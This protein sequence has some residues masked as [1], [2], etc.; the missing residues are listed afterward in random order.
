MI[1]ACFVLAVPGRAGDLA[2][3]KLLEILE[4]KGF[5]TKQE[6][7]TVKE[8]LE[9]ETAENAAP[10]DKEVAVIYDEG[11]QFR[12]RDNKTFSARIGGLVQADAVLFGSNYP[13][14]NDFDIRRARLFLEG[15]LHEHFAYKLEVELE[16]SSSDRL[17]DAYMNF[18]YF[19]YLQ[20]QVGQFKEPFSLENLISDKYLPFTERSMA[21][22]LTPARD[23]GLMLHGDL[24]GSS[25]RYAA[26]VFNGDGRDANRRSQKDEKEIT[27]RL[28]VQPFRHWGPSLLKGLQLGGSYAH[29]RL[30]TSD[31]NYR[32]RTPAQTAFFTIQPKAKFHITQ[33]IDELYRYGWEA[34]YAAGPLLIM[35]EYVRNTFT[36]V[37]LSDSEPFDFDMRAW[38]VSGLLMLSGERPSIKTGIMSKIRPRRNFN[39]RAG[40]WGA[41]GIAL[42]Y[43]H[44][45]AGRVVYSSLVNEGYSVRQAESFSV[46]FNWYLNSMCLLAL[47]YSR[48]HFKDPLFL[49]THWKGYSYFKDIEH[50]WVTR[51]QAEF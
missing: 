2:D 20:L 4:S 9:K 50:A 12:T 41:F 11:L 13:V 10:P 17:V 37:A 31:F 15:R 6:V 32:I 23:V 14:D 8:I 28:V 21:Y 1:I 22:Y 27:G 36:D 29:S 30:D 18:D 47:N 40:T 45:E 3:Q 46:A 24:L 26:G 5:L 43:Q 7:I 48:T 25:I 16:G 49:G 42:R 39:I 19:P 33:E 51:F 35:G 34:A 38:Y 44:F